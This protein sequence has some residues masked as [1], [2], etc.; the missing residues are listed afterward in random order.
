M[1]VSMLLVDLYCKVPL[2]RQQNCD[3]VERY[4][5]HELCRS[6]LHV[7]AGVGAFPWS[8]TTPCAVAVSFAITGVSS[9]CSPC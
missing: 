9:A 5:G 3:V 6:S 7:Q 4:V 2:T 8:V 1:L